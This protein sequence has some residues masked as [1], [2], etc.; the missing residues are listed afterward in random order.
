[1]KK[2]LLLALTV[3]LV[4]NADAQWSEA[5][6]AA[7][8]VVF[9]RDDLLA[10]KRTDVPGRDAVV[11]K[12]TSTLARDEYESVQLG[13][14]A[15]GG[16]LEQVKVTVESDL[17]VQIYH[18]I[19]LALKGRLGDAAVFGD[20][21]VIHNWVP[22][23]VHL[24]RG[25]LVRT[26][27][28]GDNVSLWLTI[29]APADAEPGL[30]P[31]KIRIEP[32]GKPATVL[33]LEINVRP[34][35]LQR[36]RAAFGMWMR[37]DMMPE[38]LGGRSM[39]RETLLAVYQDMADHGHNSNWFYPMGRYD[40]LPPVKCH[41]LDRLIPLAQ[42]AGLIDPRVPSLV[43]GGVPGDRKGRAVY[44]AIAWFEAEARRLGLPE[45]IVFGPDEPHYPGDA[46]V[47][48][49]A[50]TL[51]R[52]TSMRTNLDQSNMAGVYG[53]M[54]PGLCD[55][56]TVHD[57][58]VTPEVLAEAERMGSSIWAYSY[59][60]WRE[61]FDPLP[62]RYFA[63]LYTWTYK[64]GGNW[65]WAYNYGHHR[66]AW[67]MPDSHEPMP[68]TAMEARRE[69]IDDYRYL[70]MLEDCVAAFPDHAE[71][72][73][74]T[75]WLDS[76]RNRLVGAMP[77]K[78]TAGAPLAPAEFDQIREKAAEY[79]GK[80]GAIADASDRWPR[81]THTKE[82]AAYRGR[83]VQDCIAGLKAS[84][85]ASRRAAAWALYEYGPDA[86]P[87]ALALGKVLA[88]P[89]VRMPALHALEKIG[90]DAAPAVPEI[91]KLVHHPDP[92]VRI[93]AALALGEIG[94]PVQEYTRTGRRKASPHAALVVE[95]LIVSLKDEFELNSH[96]AASILGSIGAPA[97]PAVP[98][99]IG[100]LDR[101]H[102]LSSAGLGILTGLGPHAAAA[103]P[104]LLAFGKGDL[105]DTRVVE[106]LAA[107]GP[108]AAAAIPALTARASSQTGAAQAAAV[109][110]LF[111][112]RNEP[113][114]LQRLV[115]SLLGPDADKREI[116]ERLQQLGARAKPVVAQIRPLLQSEDFS[117]VHEGLQTF[118]GHVE[119]GEVP[120]VF[121]KW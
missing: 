95:P 35:R 83:P 68:I 58:S 29:H 65:V 34:F 28:A 91:A 61:N 55:V 22:E 118:L 87:A 97:K 67:F 119:A 31:G 84:D 62:Q 41:S 8:Y 69:G 76:L 108:A 66:H 21:G 88:D 4:V 57:G 42:Q 93:G 121:Y 75:A 17:A 9:E 45:F 48:H 11:S 72:A 37:E 73:N 90:P 1:M 32:A 106:A 44:E 115:D 6:R 64:L 99:A 94:A 19:D 43:V 107:I 101:H 113:G 103:V 12:I 82:E 70:Q 100:Y 16:G 18:R 109:Y 14:F 104:K 98:I 46:D 114:D 7:G 30:H 74:V 111:C 53:Y 117:E 39:P 33:D 63:G 78:V 80:F 77:N 23:N 15:I 105:A 49:Q 50:L 112:I 102:D 13:V 59:R 86:A 92:Y 3:I 56:H 120:G 110:A 81:T 2:R 85:V 51:L 38:W 36:P 24:Q 40:Q 89:D 47:V 96:T 52:G 10:L 5:E 54:T 116:V 71:S 26:I 25:D 79:I 20:Q 60:V 27:S